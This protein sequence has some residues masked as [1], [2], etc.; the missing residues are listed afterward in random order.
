MDGNKD[1]PDRL[2]RL[3]ELVRELERIADPNARA[4]AL[5]LMQLVMDLNGAAMERMMERVFALGEAGQKVIDEL[6]ND[7]AVSG[8]MVLYGLHPEDLETRVS[9]A[10][11]KIGPKLRSHG[12]DCELTSVGAGAVRVRLSAGSHS[13]GSTMAA[14]RDM[15]E[16]AIY[17]AAPDVTSLTLEGLEG[18]P[19]SG[20]VSLNTLTATAGMLQAAAHETG[21]D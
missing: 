16:G 3:A 6:G 12:A 21:G 11:Q 13:C 10:L 7:P 18:K 17:D 2:A 15:V 1:L 8:L 20:F 5:D 4:A 9:K 19:S 14:V